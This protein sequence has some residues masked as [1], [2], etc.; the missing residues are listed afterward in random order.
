M[1]LTDNVTSTTDGQTDY[2]SELPTTE[3]D[4]ESTYGNKILDED[5]QHGLHSM[6]NERT[7]RLKNALTLSAFSSG[8]CFSDL[9]DISVSDSLKSRYAPEDPP[10]HSTF[11]KYALPEARLKE[12]RAEFMYW[13]FDK[14]GSNNEGDWQR[15]IHSSVP[16]IHKNFNFQL[17]FYG[18]R[19][20][21]TR[22]IA[23]Q[24]H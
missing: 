7:R 20:N 12:L 4:S 22:V 10:S 2:S 11:N 1:I 9:S 18:F 21:Y 8:C 17:P 15:D 14:G 13:Y 6:D 3:S 19:F 5:E 23:A 24:R 16:Q